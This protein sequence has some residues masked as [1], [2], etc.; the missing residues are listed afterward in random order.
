LAGQ[1]IIRPLLNAGKEVDTLV[2]GCGWNTYGADTC[3][4]ARDVWVRCF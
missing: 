4:H 2:Y 1:L 3:T